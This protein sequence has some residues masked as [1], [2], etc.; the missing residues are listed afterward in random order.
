[1]DG[2]RDTEIAMGAFQPKHTWREERGEAGSKEGSKAKGVCRGGT[3]EQRGVA[4]G[5]SGE[6]GRAVTGGQEGTES[7][8]G[9]QVGRAGGEGRREGVKDSARR[10][11]GIWEEE[12]A[13]SKRGGGGAEEGSIREVS[14][15]GSSRSKASGREMGAEAAARAAE[16]EAAGEAGALGAAAAALGAAAGALGAAAGVEGAAAGVV[17]AAAGAAGAAAG[18]AAARQSE[19]NLSLTGI[20]SPSSTPLGSTAA[21]QPPPQLTTATVAAAPS[22][23]LITTASPAAF[24]SPR[25]AFPPNSAH[26]GTEGSYAVPAMSPTRSTTEGAER[27]SGDVSSSAGEVHCS[28]VAGVGGAGP[29]RPSTRDGAEGENQ[30]FS[31]P[32]ASP[33]SLSTTP[34][35]AASTPP[36]SLFSLT[37]TPTLSL[38]APSIHPSA[39]PLRPPSPSDLPPPLRAATPPVSRAA[40]AGETAHAPAPSQ[41]GHASQRAI[42][43][44]LSHTDTEPG[45]N[46]APYP[47]SPLPPPPPGFPGY[48]TRSPLPPS[49]ATLSPP[50]V[51]HAG[52][53][54]FTSPPVPHLPHSPLTHEGST[55]GGSS[56]ERESP[57]ISSAFGS[58]VGYGSPE[59]MQERERGGDAQEV[60]WPGVTGTESAGVAPMGACVSPAAAHPSLAEGEESA[61]ERSHALSPAQKP[62]SLHL[63]SPEPH[64]PA[65]PPPT[66]S[67]IAPLSPVHSSATGGA[68]EVGAS[69]GGA[70]SPAGAAPTSECAHGNASDLV[71]GPRGQVRVINRTSR[72]LIN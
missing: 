43:T 60:E 9:V 67:P 42:T 64:Q 31:S 44:A 23:A 46:S 5:R 47:S 48:P 52:D 39:A 29:S 18:A 55:Q 71:E 27:Q 62:H 22:S 32:S 10:G 15:G 41:G 7:P 6:E 51:F 12:T 65:S 14:M 35:T 17:G 3:E 53:S 40:A 34:R 54:A 1:M 72:H 26:A 50:P 30:P 37:G 57:V 68:E 70:M 45:G 25:S 61:G 13:A 69:T 8:G 28:P 33:H 38:L 2:G 66:P 19:A 63:P 21:A 49:R 36:S 20:A 16:A 24:S 11:G 59:D 56:A 4:G 58:H